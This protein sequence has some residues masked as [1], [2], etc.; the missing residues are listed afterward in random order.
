MANSLA[1]QRNA[2]M[3]LIMIFTV[4]A[5]IEVSDMTRVIETIPD[6]DQ[7]FFALRQSMQTLLM[8]DCGADNVELRLHHRKI[9]VFN[10]LKR[11][12]RPKLNLEQ[13]HG[14]NR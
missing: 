11:R 4:S 2:S 10:K 6:L 9:V 7:R 3:P 14:V 12:T 1:A 8:D 13:F 5:R